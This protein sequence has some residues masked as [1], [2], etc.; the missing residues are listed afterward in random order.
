M[1]RAEEI[2]AENEVFSAAGE[3]R[4]NKRRGR[5]DFRGSGGIDPHSIGV[6]TRYMRDEAQKIPAE[7]EPVAWK[8]ITLNDGQEFYIG[9]IS[10]Q[11]E[12]FTVV[13]YLA[14]FA[15]ARQ[16]ATSTNPGDVSVIRGF[17]LPKTGNYITDYFDDEIS[18]MREIHEAQVSSLIEEGFSQDEAQTSARMVRDEILLKALEESRDDE[19]R[20]IMRTLQA[21]QYEIIQAPRNSFMTIQG[22]PGTGKTA[23]ALYRL[24]YLLVNFR[25]LKPSE[26]LFVGPSQSFYEYIKSLIPQIA[27]QSVHYASIESLTNFSGRINETLDSK[28]VQTLKQSRKVLDLVSRGL[29]NRIKPPTDDYTFGQLVLPASLHNEY[30]TQA[31]TELRYSL[32]RSRLKTLIQNRFLSGRFEQ[33]LEERDLESVIQSIWPRLS[34]MEFLR[35]FFNN[36]ERIFDAANDEFTI[37]EIS[38]LYRPFSEKVSEYQW[39][40]ADVGILDYLSWLFDL[41]FPKYKYIVV[42]EAQDLTPAQRLSV[43]RRSLDGSMLLLGDLAQSSRVNGVRDWSELHKDLLHA[44]VSWKATPS[45]QELTISYRLPKQIVEEINI[46]GVLAAISDELPPLRGIRRGDESWWWWEFPPISDEDFVSED[47]FSDRISEIIDDIKSDESYAPQR[48][49]ALIVSDE[50]SAELVEGLNSRFSELKI[51]TPDQAKGREYDYVIVLNPEQIVTNSE[52]GLQELYISYTRATQRLDV[53]ISEKPDNYFFLTD[54]EDIDLSLDL[55]TNLID[56][57]ITYADFS[58][59]EEDILDRVTNHV[60]SVI[61][62]FVPRRLWSTSLV[63][64]Q[65][66]LNGPEFEDR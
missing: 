56:S 4:E 60:A 66:Q 49:I 64:V 38:S 59:I 20:N 25:D 41:D 2:V 33:R 7:N 51:H 28:E 30:L 12:D 8:K 5:E 62:D 46:S 43:A 32:G 24:A 53:M 52:F 55:R 15:V 10:L 40:P 39:S 44:G 16:R 21:G 17:D 9:E 22:G 47:F 26:I 34:P 31:K 50:V 57:P 13:N 6:I 54:D 61:R 27:E 65:G 42:D 11:G 14:D 36:R 19:M 23:V 1:S 63:A 29:W 48:S 35:D 58:S 3:V 45:H 18:A 37:S